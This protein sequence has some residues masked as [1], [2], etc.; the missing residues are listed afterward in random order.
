MEGRVEMDSAS[1]GTRSHKHKVSF[2]LFHQPKTSIGHSKEHAVPLPRRTRVTWQRTRFRE[3]DGNFF[4][5][6]I[7][8]TIMFL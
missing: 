7:H 8:S 1:K 2:A 3:G 4:D 5:S 6:R